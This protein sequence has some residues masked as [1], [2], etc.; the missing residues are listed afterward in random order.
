ML[1]GLNLNE[2]HCHS[3][4]ASLESVIV[5]VILVKIRE[6]KHM[7]QTKQKIKI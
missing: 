1:T 2:L 5:V 6:V 3:F 4:M 7:F